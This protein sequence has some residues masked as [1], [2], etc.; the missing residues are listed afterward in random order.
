M[1][2]HYLRSYLPVMNETRALTGNWHEARRYEIRL[3]GR[4]E[5]RWA[6]WFDGL[7]LAHQSD[8]STLISG[9]V[10]DQAA[11]HGL[12]QK[13]RDLGLPLVS[14]TQIEPD[15]PLRPPSSLA[16]CSPISSKKETDMNRFIRRI[17]DV[18]V[19]RP[20]LTIA[21]WAVLAAFVLGLAGAFGG[22]LVDDFVAA[23]S[24]SDQGKVLLEERFPGAAAGSAL[25]VF[26]TDEGTQLGAHRQ[27]VESALSR[28]AGLEHVT[29]VADPFQAGTVS[30]DGRIGYARITFDVPSQD[31]GP[32]ALAAVTHAIEPARTAGLSAE[33]GGDAAFINAPSKHSGAE[34]AGLLAALVVLVVAFGTIVAALVPISLALVAVAAGLGGITLLA[35]GLNVSTAGPTI[36]AMI[37]LGSTPGGWRVGDGLA[38]WPRTPRGGVTPTACRGGLGRT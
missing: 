27:A 14:V 29:A 3:M 20:W 19:R 36:G 18:S 10:A 9:C 35:G 34:A 8:G 22:A 4:L 7:S 6:A 33:L 16:N 24:E 32:A 37:G 17:A 28:I 12:L 15:Q 38:G 26:A 23:G 30:P 13:V 25:A 31:L 1:P 21:T 5:T 11:L 2:A